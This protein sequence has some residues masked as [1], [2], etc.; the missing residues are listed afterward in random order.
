MYVD[1]G[2]MRNILQRNMHPV[3]DAMREK[4]LSHTNNAFQRPLK[5]TKTK[6]KAKIKKSQIIAV[7]QQNLQ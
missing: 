3:D 6:T 2:I 5:E 7:E 4:K 1:R